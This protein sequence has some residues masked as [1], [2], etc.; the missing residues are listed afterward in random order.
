[1]LLCKNN[2]FKIISLFFICFI[3][4]INYVLFGCCYKSAGNAEAPIEKFKRIFKKMVNFKI[5][6]L[7]G[8][9]KIYDSDVEGI[10]E[11]I[12]KLKQI[13][14]NIDNVKSF[15]NCLHLKNSFNSILIN[16]AK[17]LNVDINSI[18]ENKFIININSL[19]CNEDIVPFLV[20][21]N[22]FKIAD[23]FI[24]NIDNYINRNVFLSFGKSK[25]F[26]YKF[27]VENNKLNYQNDQY[28]IFA[29]D[30]IYLEGNYVVK[31]F[32]KFNTEILEGKSI[33]NGAYVYVLS[34]MINIGPEINI[35]KTAS[36][37]YKNE[38][39]IKKNNKFN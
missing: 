17:N 7:E 26:F 6:I 5:Q 21:T 25:Y 14:N 30:G 23:D 8:H 32:D 33:N 12:A 38:D 37:Y 20:F 19:T 10:D 3:S 9:L 18:N 34:P 1:M 39:F 15:E 11:D 31:D 35:P 2:L 29:E 22:N 4:G 28:F 36:V 16:S 13:R 24:H 27:R